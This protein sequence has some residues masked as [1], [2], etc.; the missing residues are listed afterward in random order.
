M[1]LKNALLLLSS[2][3]P[4]VAV[5]GFTQVSSSKLARSFPTHRGPSSSASIG[6]RY[7][8]SGN[9]LD[10]VTS[11]FSQSPSLTD[12]AMAVNVAL[13]T[14]LSIP[15][16]TKVRSDLESKMTS[17]DERN[18]RSNLAKGYGVASPLHKVRLFD[19]SN[20]EKD[21][22]VIFYRDSASKCP[23]TCSFDRPMPNRIPFS[24]TLSLI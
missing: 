5:V 12:K 6:G 21:I 19:E 13:T 4:L 7:M 16:W 1:N 9:P 22:R 23:R 8:F 3:V 15:D 20:E 11:M 14:T 18:F 2:A 10:F 17:D 24:R